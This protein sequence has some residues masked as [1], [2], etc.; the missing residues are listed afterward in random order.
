MQLSC[1]KCRTNPGLGDWVTTAIAIGQSLL[2]R[3]DVQKG[4]QGQ[5]NLTMNSGNV[6]QANANNLP[7]LPSFR[8]SVKSPIYGKVRP[9]TWGE[10][11]RARL[12]FPGQTLGPMGQPDMVDYMADYPD[13][14]GVVYGS[15]NVTQNSVISRETVTLPE[16][17]QQ[18]D[19]V[20]VS[21]PGAF[22]SVLNSVNGINPNYLFLGALA[23]AAVLMVRK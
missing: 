23:V 19:T 14:L 13:P 7:G 5:C 2:N 21:N 16:T 22:D 8:S 17:G 1:S 6:K 12:T 15:P 4:P 20:K 10:C 11:A 3:P 18:V 9:R